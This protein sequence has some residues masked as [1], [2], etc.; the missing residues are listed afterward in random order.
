MTGPEPA[1]G[2]CGL[3]QFTYDAISGNYACDHVPVI[4]AE[5]SRRSEAA[6]KERRRQI[7]AV[8]RPSSGKIRCMENR[9]YRKEGREKEDRKREEKERDGK[10]S[11]YG[12][13]YRDERQGQGR[14]EGRKKEEGH[15]MQ[16]RHTILR[17]THSTSSRRAAI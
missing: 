15:R 14:K 2:V 12:T 3:R 1:V 13:P 11:K 10:D 5:P 4:L 17:D 16:D 6:G 8:Q 7:Q 9:V